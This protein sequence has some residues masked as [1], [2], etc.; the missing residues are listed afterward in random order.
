MPPWPGLSRPSTSLSVSGF[1]TWVPGTSPGT[2]VL[3]SN[4]NLTASLP[5]CLIVKYHGVT[6]GISSAVIV[7]SPL[8]SSSIAVMRTAF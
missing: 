5:H 7:S 3:G 1:K 8:S 4:G 6:S 2:G